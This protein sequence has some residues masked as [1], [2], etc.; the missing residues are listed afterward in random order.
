MGGHE[1]GLT[2]HRDPFDRML[3]AQALAEN[4]TLVTR[5]PLFARYWVKALK[6]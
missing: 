6:A 4:L 1:H 2:N 3:A 5:D